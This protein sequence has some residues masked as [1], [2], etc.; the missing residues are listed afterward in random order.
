MEKQREEGRHECVEDVEGWEGRYRG[1]VEG[2]RQRLEGESQERRVGFWSEDGDF[3]RRGRVGYDL[4][5][6]RGGCRVEQGRMHEAV[7]VAVAVPQ[8]HARFLLLSSDNS[9]GLQVSARF[10]VELM[11][12]CYVGGVVEGH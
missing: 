11:S 7:F 6:K 9:F 8:Q 3:L 4:N 12:Y 10:A 1:W 2:Q 5:R